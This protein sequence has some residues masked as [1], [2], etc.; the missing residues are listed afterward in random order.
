MAERVLITGAGGFIGGHLAA[1]V[2][3]LGLEVHGIDRP[4]VQCPRDWTGSWY[5][6][7]VTSAEA[8]T[9]INTVKPNY[10]FH[11][12]ALI[13]SDSLADLLSINVVGTQNVLDA[14]VGA[15]CNARILIPGSSAEYGLS[16]S[17]DM[18]I[19]EGNPLRP[20]T[21]YGVSKVAQSMLA[22]HYVS[23]YNLEVIRSRTFNLTGPGEPD[24]LVCSAFARQIV[25]IERGLRPSVLRVGNLE[26]ARDFTD[27]RDAVR[28]YWLILQSGQSG[29]IYN[30]C[31]AI[32]TMIHEI[33]DILIAEARMKIE[34]QIDLPRYT[35]GDIPLQCGDS[36]K[37][38]RLTAWSP[39]IPLRQS[40]RD[41]VNFWRSHLDKYPHVLAG[42]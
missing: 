20:V 6:A 42:I 2:A 5:V 25:E 21:L 39:Q 36:S 38:Y 32:P 34:I 13:N 19:R 33:L 9:A 31:S 29:E 40:L 12:A 18:P 24:T 23:L 10:V 3:G 7:D 11:L 35:G 15:Q 22:T 4:G 41:L 17:E 8:S 30:V 26:S 14:L 37:L 28:A 1:Y 16:L 27:V